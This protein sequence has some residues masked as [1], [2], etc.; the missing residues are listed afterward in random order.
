[1]FN[2]KQKN[3][4]IHNITNIERLTGSGL[5]TWISLRLNVI[6]KLDSPRQNLTENNWIIP[7][8]KREKK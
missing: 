5:T 8:T 6:D 3:S 7:I 2:I 1:M 4:Y